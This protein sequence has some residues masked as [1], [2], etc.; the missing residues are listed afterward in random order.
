MHEL[1]W[2]F[3]HLTRGNI[4]KVF[5]QIRR[6]IAVAELIGLPRARSGPKAALWRTI[7]SSERYH[8]MTL[9]FPSITRHYVIHKADPTENNGCEKLSAI[10]DF[11]YRLSDIAAQLSD[12][13]GPARDPL[14]IIDLQVK[15]TMLALKLDELG[16]TM[17]YEWLPG[18]DREH[19]PVHLK[20]LGYTFYY[21]KM[22]LHLPQ[23]IRRREGSTDCAERSRSACITACH[24]VVHF[25][26]AF[27]KLFDEGYFLHRVLDL[28]VY[29]AV[30]V[31]MLFGSGA[32]ARGADGRDAGLSEEH[33]GAVLQAMEH[34]VGRTG[35]E[36]GREAIKSIRAL[37][38]FVKGRQ[39]GRKSMNGYGD[40]GLVLNVP[41]MG[42]LHV[43]AKDTPTTTS[44]ATPDAVYHTPVDNEGFNIPWYLRDV[45]DN[46]Q[47]GTGENCSNGVHLNW[48]VEQ[49]DELFFHQGEELFGD[50][51]IPMW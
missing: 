7:C 9:A 13:Q 41:L 39:N 22:R 31:L 34:S 30:V 19:A 16:S 43:R 17:P 21:V 12:L 38:D 29:T 3:S 15:T 35:Y 14:P 2:S 36:M 44:V 23:L 37:D 18:E 4:S 40:E 49:A 10:Q 8:S 20:Y 24:A 48:S 25:F 28:Q 26:L 5:L 47:V 45:Y 6:V 27:S 1:T 51:G 42:K 46:A 33:L 50:P 11:L 32:F